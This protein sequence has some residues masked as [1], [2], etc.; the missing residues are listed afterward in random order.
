VTGF[1]LVAALPTRPVIRGTG[2]WLLIL[3]GVGVAI[4]LRS[5]NRLG[6]GHDRRGRA[7][8][9]FSFAAA[10]PCEHESAYYCAYIV[11][12][13][14]RPERSRAVARHAA[15]QLR[16]PRRP[17]LPRVHLHPAGSATSS[18]RSRPEGEPL[19]TLHV[20]GGGFTMPRYLRAEHPGSTSVVLEVDP[21]LVELSRTSSASSSATTSRC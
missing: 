12:D 7:R 21:L 2:A 1:V 14:D 6:V 5:G 13:P 17:E 18:P 8:R 4:W 10:H 11:E 16:R 9:L 19:D 15:P 20:G 3:L